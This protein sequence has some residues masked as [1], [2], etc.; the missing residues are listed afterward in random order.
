M[1][2]R[3]VAA[4]RG[5]GAFHRLRKVTTPG[6]DDVQPQES[7]YVDVMRPVFVIDFDSTLVTGETLDV[8]AEVVLE[9]DPEADAKAAA[10]RRITDR[11]MAGDLDFGEA[12]R[13]RLELLR[14]SREAVAEAAARMA[15][16]VT[17]SVARNRAFFEENRD[18]VYVIS[19]GFHEVVE[20]VVAAFG[21]GPEQVLANR[22]DF[23]ADGSACGVEA[24]NPLAR[25]GGK[26]EAVRNLGLE[27]EVVVVGD[28]WTDYEIR[29]AGA[30][31][32]FHAFVENV[33]REKVMAAADHIAASFDEVLHREGAGARFS[34]PRSK[35]RILLLENI[36][37]LAV[38][39]FQ[40][41]G[42]EVE[43]VRSAPD[44]AELARRLK[45]VHVLG[46]RSKTQLTATA[47]EGADRLLAAGA[48]CIGTNQ[49]DL[50]AAS[51][52]G[53]A[54][55]NAPYANTRS[56][57]ELA[58][59]MIV[60]LMRG[61]HRKSAQLHA[62]KWDKSAEGARELRGKTLGIIGYGA[63]GS[64]LSV[65]AEAMGMRVVFH[66][67][68]EKL[69][70]GNAVRRRSLG[71][72]LAEADVVSLHVDGRPENRNLIGAA[73]IQRMKPGA[74]LI[75]LS[76]GHVV[77]IGAVAQALGSGRLSGGAFDVFPEEPR[78][79]DEPFESPLRGLPNVILT[80]HI[81]GST[82]EAQENIGEFVAERLLAFLNRGDTS[83]SVNLPNLQMSE[84][85]GAHRFLHIHRNQPGVLA[86][87]NGAIAEHGLNILA[88]HLKTGEDTGYVIVDVDNAYPREVIAAMKAVPGTL[89]FR[90]L[91]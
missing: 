56:V 1:R 14:P 15:G 36:H 29:Q 10:I 70:L 11:A 62:G 19:G 65:L 61:V 21:V 75:N 18:R 52:M 37:P 80:P 53:V 50:K 43:T 28:G 49:I 3:R 73:E 84:V 77:D 81:G 23:G 85:S 30:A 58:V 57:V 45:G 5:G 44:E 83:H 42:Y 6:A 63:I 47:L 66:D 89:K 20:P 32:R 68:G 90:V 25:A 27:G 86:A 55:F 2:V 82:E 67:V 69:T 91:Y 71:E 76:R 46:L 40:R 4:G 72:V 33:K 35:M 12:L 59:G 74:A 26:A 24:S 39:R 41:E 22:L 88:Q 48:F 51:G 87:I 38:E 34:Y 78:S 31:H 64:Q 9:G 60:S 54:V 79:N 16:M 8:I 7:A 13:T 17:P